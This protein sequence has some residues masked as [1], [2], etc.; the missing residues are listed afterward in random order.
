MLTAAD[1][2]LDKGLLPTP[3]LRFGVRMQLADRK[4]NI[5]STSLEE[6]YEKKMA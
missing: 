1:W 4:Q 5:A 2:V 3:L 6:A